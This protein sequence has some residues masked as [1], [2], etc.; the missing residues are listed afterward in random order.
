MS[1]SLQYTDRFKET[2][3]DLDRQEAVRILKKL[4]W[5][6]ENAEQLS[7]ERLSNPPAGLERLC[8][9]RVGPHRVLY[10]IEHQECQ[11]IV[12]DVI[13]RKGKYRELY[14]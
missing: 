3:S 12:Y 7:H 9:Y 5:L 1:Y 4:E 14:R 10:W 8:R 2:L 11:L 13:W 6:A